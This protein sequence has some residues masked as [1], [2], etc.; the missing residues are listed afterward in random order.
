M[1]SIPDGSFSTDTLDKHVFNF[2]L[3]AMILIQVYLEKNFEKRKHSGNLMFVAA[4]R[5][6]SSLGQRFGLGDS[7]SRADRCPEP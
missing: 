4:R 6:P 5:T 2:S 3:L 1:V 7:N